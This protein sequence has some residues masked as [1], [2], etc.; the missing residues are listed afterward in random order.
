MIRIYGSVK[1]FYCRLAK[2]LCDKNKI[3]YK[4]YDIKEL[5]NWHQIQEYKKKN[6]IPKTYISMPI[7]FVGNK[8]IGG[9]AELEKILEKKSIRQRL[10]T[11]SRRKSLR[12][13]R[14]KITRKK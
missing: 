9:F 11:K 4:F 14:S 6:I 10:R 8:F 12:K 7:I 13:S 1:C 5:Q 3:F 2:E